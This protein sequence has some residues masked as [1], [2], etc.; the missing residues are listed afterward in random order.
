VTSNIFPRAVGQQL[1]VA[2]RAEGST[3]WDAE[4][5]P[6]LDAAGGAVVVAVPHADHDGTTSRVEVRAALRVPDRRSLGPNRHGKLLPHGSREHV[7]G[8]ARRSGFE[9]TTFGY[10]RSRREGRPAPGRI[11]KRSRS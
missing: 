6:Y 3:I 5:R 7:R 11:I 4:G 1:P 8:H 9:R 10:Y 2:V